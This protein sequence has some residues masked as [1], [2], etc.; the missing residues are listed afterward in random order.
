MSSRRFFE[1]SYEQLAIK[2]D[3]EL[4]K[5]FLDLRGAIN[6]AR[7]KRSNSRNLE[8][9]FCYLQKEIQDRRAYRR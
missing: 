1:Y 9:E 5:I 4:R 3:A 6:K 2:T 8:I 7:R